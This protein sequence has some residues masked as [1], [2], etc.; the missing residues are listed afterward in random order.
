MITFKIQNIIKD[1]ESSKLNDDWEL[2]INIEGDLKIY[3]NDSLFFNDPMM[4]IV[5]LAVELKKWLSKPIGT[6][7]KYETI[8]DEEENILNISAISDNQFTFNSAWQETEFKD[9]FNREEVISFVSSY[10]NYVVS[11]IDKEL[12]ANLSER[13]GL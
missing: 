8:D 2:L 3:L 12:K 11:S 10:I 6:S 4:T 9:T 7:F 13:L 1:P 5:E